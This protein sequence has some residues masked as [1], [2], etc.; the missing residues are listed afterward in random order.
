MMDRKAAN[1][2]IIDDMIARL[3]SLKSLDRFE[4]VNYLR[5]TEADLAINR[6]ANNL[7]TRLEPSDDV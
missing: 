7:T 5:L 4:K 6:L 3:Q 2:Q 1:T